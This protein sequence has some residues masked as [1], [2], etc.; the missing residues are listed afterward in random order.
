M[1]PLGIGFV[2]AVVGAVFVFVVYTAWV[3][4]RVLW[5]IVSAL[6]QQSAQA[7]RKSPTQESTISTP[8]ATPAK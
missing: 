2:G 4:H 6:Q 1:K 3:D 7:Q 8:P 5:E